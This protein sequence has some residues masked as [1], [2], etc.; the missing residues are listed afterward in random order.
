[1][2]PN[3]ESTEILIIRHG[4]TT[5]NVKAQL[6]GHMDIPLN[7][8]GTRQAKSLATHLE[9]E[10][11]DAIFSSDLHRAVQTAA[12]IARLQGVGTRID[13][14]FR[15]RCFGGFE[16]HLKSDLPQLYP[17]EYA[18]WRSRDPDF[19]F[20]PSPTDENYTGESTREFHQRIM[21]A[22]HH[23]AN[24][25]TGKKIAIVTHGGVLESVYR[26][27]NNLPLEAERKVTI[28]NASIN[29]FIWKDGRLNLVKWGEIATQSTKSTSELIDELM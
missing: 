18:H 6:Q 5:W 16:G 15:E 3:S 2:I 24:Q 28:F 1:M 21:N 25:F 11:L 8:E 13:K 4:E 20:P 23:Q 14:E 17:Q 27:A 10:K 9:T 19:H 7:A 29:R 12:E 22:L 26:E